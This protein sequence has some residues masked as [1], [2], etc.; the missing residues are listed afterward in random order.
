MLLSHLIY[1]LKTAGL[2]TTQFGLFWQPSA[3]SK[4]AE[5]Q[6][7]VILTQQVGLLCLTQHAGLVFY[8]LKLLHR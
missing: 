4:R 7:W 3:G 8:G 1:T 5:T 6:R 2:K